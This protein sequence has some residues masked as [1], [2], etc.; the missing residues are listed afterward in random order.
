MGKARELF[1]EY[2]ASLGVSLCFEN[3][4]QELAELPGH[5]APPMAGPACLC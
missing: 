2:A 4:D 3:F 5:Y 1:L